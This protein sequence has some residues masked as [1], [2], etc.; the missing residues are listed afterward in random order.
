MIEDYLS[1]ESVAA[2]TRKYHLNSKTIRKT[3]TE[4]GV[5]LRS[6][7][8]QV[9]ITNRR[10]DRLG[11][12]QNQKRGKD[13]HKWTGGILRRSNYLLQYL[14]VDHWLYQFGI[15][16][17]GKN[18]RNRY[19]LQHRL[20]MAEYLERPLRKW[21][22]VHH[23]DGD[24][25]NNELSNLQLRIGKHGIGVVMVCKDCGSDR[26]DYKELT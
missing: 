14:P 22:T 16:G 6:Q 4:A 20:V 1:G 9:S 17:G 18:A 8:E 15:S 23:I 12:G 24:T 7:Q 13:S 11:N 26:F 3:L 25:F 21:E 2:L 5:I 19:M 10:V